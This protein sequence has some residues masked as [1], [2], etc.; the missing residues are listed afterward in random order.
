MLL[1]KA[2]LQGSGDSHC[3]ELVENASYCSS[4]PCI[5]IQVKDE[6]EEI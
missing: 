3:S 4:L 1:Y 2:S 5:E 6:V